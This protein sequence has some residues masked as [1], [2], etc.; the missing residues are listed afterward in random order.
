MGVSINLLDTPFVLL[1]SKSVSQNYIAI[2]L[3]LIVLLL[4]LEVSS[5]VGTRWTL[6]RSLLTLDDVTA[7]TALPPNL[8]ITYEEIAIGDAAQELQITTLVLS[9]YQ[10]YATEYLS[11][12]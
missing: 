2:Q 12:L 8:A 10:C 11:Y 7:V 4:W 3:L 9:L 6:Q 5:W 1:L